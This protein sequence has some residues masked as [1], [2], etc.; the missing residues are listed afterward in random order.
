MVAV[1]QTAQLSLRPRGSDAAL[2]QFSVPLHV[3]RRNGLAPGVDA[4]VSL[5]AE[6]IHLM[7]PEPAETRARRAEP[8]AP[9][10]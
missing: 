1:G 8:A 6:G 5:L 2:L 3:A 10:E 7:A 9:G 4:G